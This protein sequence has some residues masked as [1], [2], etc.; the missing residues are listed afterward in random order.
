MY[1]KDLCDDLTPSHCMQTCAH[2]AKIMPRKAKPALS[3]P[4]GARKK[5]ALSSFQ[6]L[7]KKREKEEKGRL[8]AERRVRA[9]ERELKKEQEEK[10]KEEE[11]RWKLEGELGCEREKRQDAIHA[12]VRARLEAMGLRTPF[13]GATACLFGAHCAWGCTLVLNV[14]IAHMHA[15]ARGVVHMYAFAMFCVHKNLHSAR[16]PRGPRGYRAEGT[17]K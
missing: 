16:L 10:K 13:R 15:F 5:D 8:K 11:A 4:S 6:V 3:G 12:G 9:L 2:V 17:L 1:K 14:G 7:Q